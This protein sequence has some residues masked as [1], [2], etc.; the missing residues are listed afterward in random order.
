MELLVATWTVR[1]AL[2]GAVVVAG[3]SLSAGAALIDAVDRA[4]LAAFALTVLG[5]QLI[6]WLET[7]EQRMLRLRTRREAALARQRTPGKAGREPQ[8]HKA[9]PARRPRSE[10]QPAGAPDALSGAD[11]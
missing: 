3:V 8:A 5:R 9:K 2:V 10:P 1:L 11:A 7:P 4:V 6:G